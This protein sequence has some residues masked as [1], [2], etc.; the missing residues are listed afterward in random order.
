MM[1]IS[2]ETENLGARRSDVGR[3]QKRWN[4]LVKKR[5]KN[6]S[7]PKIG[8]RKKSANNVDPFFWIE[9]EP[10]FALNF[11]TGF[12]FPIYSFLFG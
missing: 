9:L 6:G 10:P 1:R 12:L 7:S 2:R 4:K 11:L 8:K 3:G 5:R